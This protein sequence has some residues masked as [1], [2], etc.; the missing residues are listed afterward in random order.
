MIIMFSLELHLRVSRIFPWQDSICHVLGFNCSSYI[1]LSIMNIIKRQDFHWPLLIFSSLASALWTM[2]CVLYLLTTWRF[3]YVFCRA[4]NVHHF[5]FHDR[6]I[7][8]S[9]TSSKELRIRLFM[10]FCSW[11]FL[12]IFNPGRHCFILFMFYSTFQ[13]RK[14]KSL[15]FYL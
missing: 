7:I 6:S 10:L 12:L 13:M 1:I 3:Q 11:N 9:K 14:L 5:W 8:K 2:L 15:F 4:S